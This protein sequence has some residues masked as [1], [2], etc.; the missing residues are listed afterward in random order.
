MTTIFARVNNALATLSPA[1]PFAMVPYLGDLPATFISYQL[2]SGTLEQAADNVETER[3]YRVQVNVCSTSG[4]N[5]LTNFAGSWCYFS[6]L[7][8]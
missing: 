8:K 3:S 2:I 5:S 6:S 7:L 4:L 1:I